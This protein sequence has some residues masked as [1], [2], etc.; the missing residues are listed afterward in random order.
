MTETEKAVDRT[1][2]E[3]R[4]L[5]VDMEGY[6]SKHEIVYQAP[7]TEGWEGF[8]LGNG[9]YG[10]MLWARSEGLVFQANHTDALELPD[11]EK[12][13]EGWAVLRSVARLEI[14]HPLPVHDWPYMNRYHAALSL[15]RAQ[16][17]L[18]AET[19]FGTFRCGAYLHACHPVAIIR[20]RADYSG[21]LAGQGAPVR[22]SLER[23]GSRVF[24][25]W[26]GSQQGGASMD[27]GTTAVSVERQG[28][29]LCLLARFRGVSVGLRCRVL[30]SRGAHASATISHTHRGEIE[31]PAADEQDFTVFLACAT[32]H[33]SSDPLAA[34]LASLD[35]VTA[36]DAGALEE[37]HLAWWREFWSRSFL[38]IGDDYA[39]NLYYIHHYL[40]GSS[41]R[42]R[43]PPVFNGGLWIWNRD[44][45]NW[46][47]PHNW[48]EQMSF[49]CLPAAGRADLLAPYLRTYDDLKPQALAA[50]RERGYQGLRWAEMHD[51]SG[52]QLAL[53]SPSF[54]LNHTPAAQIALFYWWH[55]RYTGDRHCFMEQGLP[56]IEAVGDFYLGL[57]KWNEAGGEYEIPLASTYEDERPWRFTNS[58]TNLAMARAVFKIL[59]TSADEAGTAACITREKRTKWAHMLAHLPPYLTNDRD[60]GRGVTLGSGLVDGKA[61]PDAETHGHGP[62]FCPIFPAGDLGLKH[63]GSALF[64]AARNTLA[65]HSPNAQAI[66]PVLI[67]AARLGMAEEAGRRM[68]FMIRNLQHFPNG[69]FFNIDHWSG[70]SRRTGPTGSKPGEEREEG[71]EH[72]ALQR[73][74]LDDRAIRFR[75]VKVLPYAPDGVD[76]HVADTP[77]WPF[78]QMGMESLGHFTAGL[79]EMLLQSHEGAIR[80]FPAVPDEWEVAFTLHAEGGFLVTGRRAP[81]SVPDCIEITS[82][83]GGECAV[84][85]PW[86][87]ARV[88]RPSGEAVPTRDRDDGAVAFDTRIDGVYLLLPPGAPVPPGPVHYGGTRNTAPKRYEEAMIG[89]PS[90]W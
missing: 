83:R 63:R 38:H 72:A 45:R 6:L 52:R 35:A 12:R 50:T 11:P 64:A 48:N 89:K 10:G 80:V 88:L 3:S 1:A 37:E 18:R 49:W 60:R 42:G 70:L 39:E 5:G 24:G 2:V 55:Y 29:D 65:T 17:D 32:S 79:Q 76:A 57:I 33:S 46:V 62:V 30:G 68:R 58:I 27:L 4:P 78:I 87:T 90:E 28:T 51:F 71:T 47:N 73:D 36:K 67:L 23:W 66:T 81:H 14:T 77:A 43:L 34:T 8:P 69:M 9:S 13:N 20:C 75:G 19:A 41:C 86:P 61:L 53:G 26:Y 59:V 15:Y 16:T 74:Y 21:D 44:I 7:A 22:I 85:L 56:F 54:A 40:M 82:R 84:W 25:W 31:V